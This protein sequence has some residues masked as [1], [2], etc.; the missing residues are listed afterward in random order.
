[1][2]HKINAEIHVHLHNVGNDSIAAGVREILE[3]LFI[4]H[5]ENG[6]I[7][8]AITDLQN[9]FDAAKAKI[10]KVLAD[11]T[12]ALND[13]KAKI[14]ALNQSGG[15]DPAELAALSSDVSDTSDNFSAAA[16]ALEGIIA[17]DDPATPASGGTGT[18]TDLTATP[19]ARK[20]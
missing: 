3:K 17:V 19:Q 1:M 18:G 5:Q 16:D 20:L 2:E 7:M 6:G 14:D 9:K 11:A 13:L 15:A 12:T 8:T 10:V 4:L